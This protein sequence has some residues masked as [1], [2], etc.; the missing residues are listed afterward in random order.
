MQAS[1]RRGCGCGVAGCDGLCSSAAVPQAY[2]HT[3][4]DLYGYA[5][6]H[7]TEQEHEAAAGVGASRPWP[8]GIVNC[9]LLPIFPTDPK[10]RRLLSSAK[11]N[12]A[13]AKA[14]AAWRG[15]VRRRILPRLRALRP[16]LVVISAGFD[17]S[18]HDR[19]YWLGE[20]DFAWA[21]REIVGAANALREADCGV[22]SV[23]EGGYAT[24]V[25]P[26]GKPASAQAGVEW[27]PGDSGLGRCV[28]AF[29]DALA[30]T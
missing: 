19:Y 1:L 17:A 26:V 11:R 16:D 12:A 23:L 2:P 4:C 7:G 6:T 22:V 20:E 15:A 9:P 13:K 3:R 18:E 30:E 8:G 28:R 29:V 25:R 5:D 27:S 10:A 21:A 24:Q 14:S